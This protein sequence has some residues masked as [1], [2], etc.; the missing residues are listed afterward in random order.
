MRYQELI[1][2]SVTN[3]A[4]A[5]LKDEYLQL[6]VVGFTDKKGYAL[7]HEARMILVSKRGEV[8][9]RRK[10]LKSDSLAF[11]KQVDSEARRITLEL[12]SIENHLREQQDIIDKEKVRIKEEAERIQKEK[13]EAIRHRLNERVKNLISVGAEFLL[14][15]IEQLSDEDFDLMLSRVTARFNEET[16]QAELIAEELLKAK[17]EQDRTAKILREQQEENGRL[18][19]EAARRDREAL[20]RELA[21]RKDR[22]RKE[23]EINDAIIAVKIK[24]EKLAR[25]NLADQAM[26]DSVKI[27]FPTIEICWGEICRLRKEAAQKI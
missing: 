8:E 23:K 26:F 9:K 3:A 25:E 22:E 27:E 17:K 6:K 16:K 14:E 21:E 12:E 20:D 18:I 1:T 4:I 13:S 5:K 7:C 2:Y 24:A 19:L 11:G 10:E 15:E